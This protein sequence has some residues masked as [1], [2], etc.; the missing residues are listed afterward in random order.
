MEFFLLVNTSDKLV[1]C[2]NCKITKGTVIEGGD[3]D[4]DTKLTVHLVGLYWW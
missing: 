4:D 1:G 3:D 2:N